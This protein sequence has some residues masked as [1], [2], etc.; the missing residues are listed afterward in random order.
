MASAFSL[1][2]PGLQET[3]SEQ[4]AWSGGNDAV[5]YTLE[6]PPERGKM[7]PLAPTPYLSQEVLETQARGTLH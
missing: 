5:G 1:W 3:E 4:P 6:V 7:V 2:L